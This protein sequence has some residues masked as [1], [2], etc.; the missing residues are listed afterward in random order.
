MSLSNVI[1]FMNNTSDT[2]KTMSSTSIKD[3]Y[4]MFSC[5]MSKARNGDVIIVTNSKATTKWYT[6]DADSNRS[7]GMLRNPLKKN[8]ES[9]SKRITTKKP[10][11]I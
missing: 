1:C 6:T 9:T 11:R 5:D 8:G 2:F 7:G 4:I 3:I 10:I